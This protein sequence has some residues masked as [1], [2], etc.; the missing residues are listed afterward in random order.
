[1]DPES[2]ITAGGEG[3][4]REVAEFVDNLKARLK[5]VERGSEWTRQ[6]EDLLKKINSS[7]DP[8]VAYGQ[9]LLDIA[10]GSDLLEVVVQY[11]GISEGCEA[12][13]NTLIANMAASCDPREMFTIFFEVIN[14]YTKPR[15]LHLC[16]P[17]LHGLSIVFPRIRR[18]QVE[19]F[20]EAIP[21]LLEVGRAALEVKG[22]TGEN[23][24]DDEVSESRAQQ[25]PHYRVPDNIPSKLVEKLVN[26]GKTMREVYTGDDNQRLS[27]ILVLYILRLLSLASCSTSAI[28]GGVPEIVME[29]MNLL[30]SSNLFVKEILTTR[31]L[32]EI[33]DRYS[34]EDEDQILRT[35][36]EA[37]VGAALAV[38]WYIFNKDS[39][40]VT[41]VF[42]FL[43]SQ[44]EN[45]GRQ[46]VSYV[47]NMAS[48]LLVPLGWNQDV[49]FQQKGVTLLTSILEV[50]KTISNTSHTVQPDDSSIYIMPALK[51]IQDLV[52]HT[53]NTKLRR[54]A[55]A[56]LI[57]TIKQT[58]PAPERFQALFDII[59][60]CD[61][62]SLVSLLLNCV[63]D[64]V[65]SA[66]PPVVDLPIQR[67]SDG[68]STSA[69]AETFTEGMTLSP[70]VNSQVLQFIQC[71]LRTRDGDLAELP[72]NIDA[73]VSALNLYRFLLIRE[74]SGNTNYTQVLGHDELVKGRTYWLL[75]IREQALSV[76]SVLER[77]D[78]ETDSSAD[79]MLA[80]DCLQSV[81][82]RCLE[83]VEEVQRGLPN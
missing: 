58:L 32:E 8:N 7:L 82:Y 70:F 11:A 56:L 12:N 1:M 68:L 38:Y 30:S 67:G 62:P 24:S 2:E 6:C 73:V 74:S 66:W 71:V 34:D 57:K 83:I 9:E 75:P 21:G 17:L 4:G 27:D 37:T 42:D 45:S 64:E 18:R 72:R 63:K 61:H 15:T 52:V 79:M 47:I 35:R 65:V 78:S 76:R 46:G 59:T 19:F 25:I 54:E 14:I 13:I 53:A 81:L 44:V 26:L 36:F 77:V 41:L 28:E 60:N 31:K 22:A 80:I 10:G 40:T 16:I 3:Q 48:I 51:R 39:S 49:S 29:V 43:K 20:K 69:S 55:Y 23:D 33:L 50:L 5:E